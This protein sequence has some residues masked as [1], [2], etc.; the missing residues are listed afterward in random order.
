MK[1]IIKEFDPVVYPRKVWVATGDIDE[2]TS[3]FE[4]DDGT[5]IVLKE[6][7]YFG[8]TIGHV[9]NKEQAKLGV[10]VYFRYI[11]KPSQAM[12]EAVHVANKIF[13]DLNITFNLDEDEHY[14]YF[15]TWICECILSAVNTGTTDSYKEDE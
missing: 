7:G 3:Q 2:I 9:T 10:L 12:H 5:P 8:V 14:A 6:K 1:T 4:Y 11:E 13:R 15:V